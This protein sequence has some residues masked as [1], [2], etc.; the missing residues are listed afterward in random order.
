[1]KVQVDFEIDTQ[2]KTTH[3]QN[4]YM[5]GPLIRLLPLGLLEMLRLF[6]C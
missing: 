2:I 1:M 4:V 3:T 6:W 5:R